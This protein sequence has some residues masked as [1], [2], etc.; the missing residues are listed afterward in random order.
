[1]AWPLDMVGAAVDGPDAAAGN[2][3]TKMAWVLRASVSV[4]VV[5]ADPS[6]PMTKPS[7]VA[8][9]PAVAPCANVQAS[10]AVNDTVPEATTP[11]CKKLL[12][13][14]TYVT[15]ILSVFYH[16]YSSR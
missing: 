10:E 3:F 4:T 8:T 14:S 2:V 7:Q 15:S 11:T 1:V 9:A 12:G 5:A 16:A 13:P 6:A